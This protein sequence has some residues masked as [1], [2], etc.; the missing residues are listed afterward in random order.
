M[1]QNL[2][3]LSINV[4]RAYE[5]SKS[6]N[7]TIS[8][9]G[10]ADSPDGERTNKENVAT[11]RYFYDAQ[12]DDVADIV[13][14]VAAISSSEILSSYTARYETIQDIESRVEL[15]KSSELSP[16]IE[17]KGSVLNLLK[18][19]IDRLNLSIRQVNSIVAV[20]ITIA[21][22]AQSDTVKA[23]HIAEAIQYQSS[24]NN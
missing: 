18:V 19:A 16:K 23:E 2:V 15:V 17:L 8:I 14:E 24:N 5:I 6:G 1:T 21:K 12:W 4:S 7:H 10:A 20:S 3:A 9:I 11:L 13:V 22:M